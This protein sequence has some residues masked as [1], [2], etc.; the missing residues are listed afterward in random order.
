MLCY[1]LESLSIS[2]KKPKT[3]HLTEGK[4]N[5]KENNIKKAFYRDVKT[6]LL[7]K[8]INLLKKMQQYQNKAS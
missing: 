1:A 7:M 2:R 4:D 3:K 6:Q 8:C 5:K